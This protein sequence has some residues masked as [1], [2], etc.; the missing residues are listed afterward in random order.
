[1]ILPILAVVLGGAFASSASAVAVDTDRDGLTDAFERNWSRTDPL[2]V[3]SDGDGLW[4]AWEDPDLDQ[5]THGAEE[6]RHQSARR[7]HR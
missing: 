1:M 4:D 7:R 3:D 6:P 2:R 5:L